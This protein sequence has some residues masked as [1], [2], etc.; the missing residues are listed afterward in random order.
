M[1]W[2]TITRTGVLHFLS[3]RLFIVLI[4]IT[5]IYPV[6]AGAQIWLAQRFPEQRLLAVDGEFFRRFL[7]IQTF[8]F[9]VLGVFPGTGL[10]SND[11]KGNAIQ[12]YLS[13]PLTR[14]DY[15]AG[16]FGILAT[17][18]LG[19]TLLPGLILFGLQVGF[20]QDSKF[21]LQY[22]WIP[23]ALAAYAVVG[24]IAW[25]LIVLALSSMSKNS[26][27]VGILL[28]SLT[29][30]SSGFSLFL[31]GIF[32]SS[33]MIVLSVLDDLKLLTYVFFGGESEYGPHGFGAAVM[34]MLLAGLSALVLRAR[35]RAVEVVT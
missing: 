29:L 14:L 22:W 26:R 4:T 16:K 10:I 20:S 8:W 9:L 12:L 19:V 33:G 15:V 6:A 31:R 11:L 25:G 28:L 18:M 7:E 34:L 27:Y 21:I 35:V 13:K 24:T 2:W 3:R 1:R 23:A 5:M 32:N 17:F 30:F